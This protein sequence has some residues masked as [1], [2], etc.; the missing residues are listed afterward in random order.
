MN[1]DKVNYKGYEVEYKCI[2]GECGWI[3]KGHGTIYFTLEG[4]KEEIDIWVEED[5]Y[6]NN[7]SEEEREAYNNIGIEEYPDLD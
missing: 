1:K 5:E 3:I 2:Y 4:A 7:L 6:E